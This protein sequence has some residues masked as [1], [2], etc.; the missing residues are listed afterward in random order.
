MSVFFSFT[1][2]SF[3]V[4]KKKQSLSKQNLFIEIKFEDAEGQC[5][6]LVRWNFV[7]QIYMEV[8]TVFLICKPEPFPIVTDST[9]W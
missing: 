2:K 6:T 9:P 8:E 5:K 3:P 1:E 7:F 4:T